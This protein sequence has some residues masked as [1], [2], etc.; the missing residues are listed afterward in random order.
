MIATHTKGEWLVDK[1]GDVE[2]PG[3]SFF[4]GSNGDPDKFANA[5]LMAAAPELLEALQFVSKYIAFRTLR[6]E[7]FPSQ[8]TN[9][10]EKAISKAVIQLQPD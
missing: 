8:L 1:D 2:L 4:L 3:G 10:V 6:G 5:T 7:T 9:A